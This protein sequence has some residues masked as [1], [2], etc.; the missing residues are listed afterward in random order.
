MTAPKVMSWADY[1]AL[2]RENFTRL[3]TISESPALY[4]WTCDHPPEETAATALGRYVHRVILEP[5]DPG[6]DFAIFPGARRAGKEWETFAKANSGKTIFRQDEIDDMADLIATVRAHP[7]ATRL[8]SGGIAE[9]VITW[10]DEPTQI[11]CKARP[12]YIYPARRHLIDLKTSKSIDVRRFGHDL[13]RY[14]YHGQLAH[15]S[16]GIT[17]ALG[18]TPERHTLIVVEKSPP[19]DVAIFD[20]D[21]DT[22][23][24]GE[25]FV[26]GCLDRL[27]ECRKT[28]SWPGRHPKPVTLD[29]SNLPPW[30]FGGGIPEFVFAEE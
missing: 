18:W 10:T 9:G 19:Y 23:N 29:S 16:A 22:I 20:L 24:M 7:E 5:D 28:N 25:E 1:F 12:D 21:A 14:A 26:R 6:D 3:K 27:A 2:D 17:T 13:A 8:L 4:R 15:Y 30:I 11:R